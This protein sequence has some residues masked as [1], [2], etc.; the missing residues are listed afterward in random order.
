VRG[1]P[2]SKAPLGVVREA[3][4]RGPVVLGL[5]EQLTEVIA[6]RRALAPM[7]LRPLL[8]VSALLLV[9]LPARAEQPHDAVTLEYFPSRATGALCP[10]ADFFAL[11]VQIRL[12]YELVQPTASN[13]LT[14]K[15]DRANGLFRAVG[16]IRDEDGNVVFART[17]SE[18][19][20]TRA[21]VSM[22]ILVSVKF[23]RA[24]EEPEPSPASLVE[25][26]P[27]GPPAPE[28]EPEPESPPRPVAPSPLPERRL[29]QAGLASVFS[30]GTAPTL[31]GGVSGFLGVRWPST[32]LALEGRALFAPSA[33]IEGATV[34]S[35]YHFTHAAISGSG[36]YHPAWALVFACARIE[37]GSLFIGNPGLEVNPSQLAI[38]GLGFRLGGDWALTPWLALRIHADV[39]GQPLTNI[40]KDNV[41]GPIIWTQPRVSGSFGAGPVLTFSGI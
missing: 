4:K 23:T 10:E 13:H 9:A 22:A 40:I 1:D 2:S 3:T 25:P 29:F 38:L 34:H 39:L 41:A 36:C 20:C 5:A 35:G 11:E 32:S 21:I 6:S 31:L 33:T 15:V 16:E 19:D 28:P 30:T 18:I 14:L 37:A 24:P 17:Y 7:L 27:P 26:S 12:G 8:L